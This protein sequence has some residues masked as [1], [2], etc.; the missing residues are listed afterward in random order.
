MSFYSFLHCHVLSFFLTHDLHCPTTLFIHFIL[1]LFILIFFH[2]FHSFLPSF[3]L[4]VISFLPS[5]HVFF[6]RSLLYSFHFIFFSSYS[7]NTL[8]FCLSLSFLPFFCSSFL[9]FTF[10]IPSF[11]HLCLPFISRPSFGFKPSFLQF[12]FFPPSYLPFISFLPIP[13]IFSSFLISFFLPN[14]T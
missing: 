1:F 8:H 14:F 12:P 6:F 9:Y 13:F 10:L 11:L 4:S 5:R 2:P 7:Y 3:L